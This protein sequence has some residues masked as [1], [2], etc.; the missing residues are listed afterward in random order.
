M[1]GS[2]DGMTGFF[3]FSSQLFP[4]YLPKKYREPNSFWHANTSF[5][6]CFT[7]KLSGNCIHRL[8]VP[9]PKSTENRWKNRSFGHN[10]RHSV[11]IMFCQQEKVL[12]IVISTY[13]PILVQIVWVEAEIA[14]FTCSPVMISNSGWTSVRGPYPASVKFFDG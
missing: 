12:K 10:F 13:T 5:H 7:H 9:E 6:L 8:L 11:L 1:I 14:V 2:Y 3:M 4:L